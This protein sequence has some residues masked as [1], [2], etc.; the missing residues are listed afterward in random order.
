M[1][2]I[3]KNGYRTILI[4]PPWP[5]RGGGKIKRGADRHYS[6]LSVKDIAAL[7]IRKLAH[8]EGAHIYLWCTN[9]YLADAVSILREW[10]FTYKTCIT[11]LKDGKP[12]LGQYFR[13]RTEHILFGTC[14]DALPYK[15]CPSTG[16]R[17]QGVTGFTAPRREHSRKPEE[18]RQMAERVS[19]EPRIEIFGREH[20]AGW[21][22]VG[23]AIDGKDIREILQNAHEQSTHIRAKGEPL[24]SLCSESSNTVCSNGIFNIPPDSH[25]EGA[26]ANAMENS[27]RAVL[28]KN[29]SLER[30]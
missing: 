26:R 13:G 22:V 12:G 30:R 28:Q 8:V 24:H 23:D 10:G 11:W 9:N 29:E 15:T 5:E 16:K 14:G 2:G 19:H 21:T 20:V 6:L 3:I 1:T 17:M 4:D 18:L 7:P 25:R 27:G